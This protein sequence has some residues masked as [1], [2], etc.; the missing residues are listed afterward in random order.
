M[1]PWDLWKWESKK[2]NRLQLKEYKEI[3]EH[4]LWE[5]ELLISSLLC[6]EKIL[7]AKLFSKKEIKENNNNILPL[8]LPWRKPQKG[9]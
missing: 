2:G 8:W 5:N 4:L 9:P 1:S 7:K 6:G 3:S